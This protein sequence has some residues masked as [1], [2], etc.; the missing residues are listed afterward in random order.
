MSVIYSGSI[1]NDVGDQLTLIPQSQSSQSVAFT[2]C[3]CVVKETTRMRARCTSSPGSHP[4]RPVTS[5]APPGSDCFLKRKKKKRNR[6]VVRAQIPACPLVESIGVSGVCVGHVASPSLRYFLRGD[7]R[8]FDS[9]QGGV[10]FLAERDRDQCV[11]GSR[12]QNTSLL[13]GQTASPSR[14]QHLDMPGIAAPE[15]INTL[16]F[17]CALISMRL[18]YPTLKS[19]AELSSRKHK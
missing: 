5:L 12:D 15:V 14:R 19:S 13:W 9:T 7:E 8:S 11:G 17:N 4:D 2:A 16:Y 10:K 1:V 6:G 3:Y 18:Y